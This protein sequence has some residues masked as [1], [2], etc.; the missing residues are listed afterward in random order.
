MEVLE[1]RETSHLIIQHL[2]ASGIKIKRWKGSLSDQQ[3]KV[4]TPCIGLF[5]IP[6]H[7][8]PLSESDEAVPQFL[9]DICQFLSQHLHSEGLFR[10]SGSVTRTKALKAKLEAGERCWDSAL[11][12][13]VSSLLKQFLRDLPDPLISAQ[14]QEPLCRIQQ[15]AEDERGPNTVLITCLMPPLNTH[16]LRYFCKF[17]QTVASRCDEN[18]MDLPNLAVV[19]APN[20]FRNLE[21]NEK[22][23]GIAER[24]LQLQVAV[25]Q[26]LVAH[27]S[28]IGRLPEFIQQKIRPPLDEGSGCR[29][30][31][32]LEIGGNNLP[33]G[34]GGGGNRRRRQ[35][36]SMGEI[37]NGALSKLK[38]GRTPTN[39]QLPDRKPGAHVL[40]T[41]GA[42][43]ER[44]TQSAASTE[45]SPTLST[46]FNAKR[47]VSEDGIQGLELSAKKRKSSLE[48]PQED[49]LAD[50]AR[51]E[52]TASSKGY[53][54]PRK[55]S[56]HAPIS[57]ARIPEQSLGVKSLPATPVAHPQ[58]NTKRRRSKRQESKRVQ[59]KHSGRS[60]RASPVV[61]VRKNQ[62]PLFSSTPDAKTLEPTGWFLMKKK[63]TE[64][65]EGQKFP[66]RDL[67]S[68]LRTDELPNDQEGAAIKLVS[69]ENIS[70]TSSISE[71]AAVF[72]SEEMQRTL[73]SEVRIKNNKATPSFLTS[74]LPMM[75][76][77]PS[78]R[79]W[80]TTREQG[81]HSQGKLGNWKA[82]GLPVNHHLTGIHELKN[83]STK[84][85]GIRRS[86]S[87][88]ENIS[89]TVENELTEA[90][91]EATLESPTCCKERQEFDRYDSSI[92]KTDIT[93]GKLFR[94]VDTSIPLGPL[95][96]CIDVNHEPDI[97]HKLELE[98]PL[99]LD[100]LDDKQSTEGSALENIDMFSPQLSGGDTQHSE[101][102]FME[103]LSPPKW[104]NNLHTD[105]FQNGHISRLHMYSK[106]VAPNRS[107]QK[108]VLNLHCS[109]VQLYGSLLESTDM[110]GRERTLRRQGARRYGRS[111][112]YE[113]AL[114]IKASAATSLH[115]DEPCEGHVDVSPSQ[116]EADVDSKMTSQT[117]VQPL[118]SP[119]K[120][121]SGCN[122]QIFI[123]RKHITLTFGGLRS[124]RE[125]TEVKSAKDV[126]EKSPS[127][128]KPSSVS[129]ENAEA[130]LESPDSPFSTSVS[131]TNLWWKSHFQAERPKDTAVPEMMMR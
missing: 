53:I 56:S 83:K 76:S 61:I 27:A 63:V 21:V 103:S 43:E 54:S 99:V 93:D 31:E 129:N 8:L 89:E 25:V 44:K 72:S 81:H 115:I 51:L 42:E 2:K 98:L 59:R 33:A 96:T 7:R 104:E 5:G 39:T 32:A 77:P 71:D 29:T 105:G 106:Q 19:F 121:M 23:T 86:L 91:R 45:R 28:E 15:L 97:Q 48:T 1:Q 46:S 68:D 120:R 126:L 37:F 108:L 4:A 122:R 88:P 102:T 111:L 60:T 67:Q 113:S 26:T 9:V 101:N 128:Q 119:V 12:C 116:I 107:V 114:A 3:E 74:A 24:Q 13:D 112:S 30:P 50:N 65:F 85:C 49:V 109:P 100:N 62:V 47:K 16:T 94:D 78:W 70:K 95:F 57:P 17:L 87:L 75:Q 84:P 82:G 20:L 36:Q 92:G 131:P 38:A 90:L 58:S 22:L 52:I 14:L 117:K 18:K 64:A 80:F 130:D 35:R 123:S 69:E 110:E 125:E 11:P 41:N 79:R 124:K 10:K 40:N 6:L 127:P 73:V 34:I 66:G 118:K 55:R